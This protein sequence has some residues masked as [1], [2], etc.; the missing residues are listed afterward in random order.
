M[1]CRVTCMYIRMY[2]HVDM[3]RAFKGGRGQGIPT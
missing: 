2:R 3:E 1:P